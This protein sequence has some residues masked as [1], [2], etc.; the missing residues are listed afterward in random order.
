[1]EC[2]QDSS[3][4]YKLELQPTGHQYNKTNLTATIWTQKPIISVHTL[5]SENSL[6]GSAYINCSH[7]K[8]KTT[9]EG[10]QGGELNHIISIELTFQLVYPRH[11]AALNSRDCRLWH[12]MKHS[13]HLIIYH[14]FPLRKHHLSRT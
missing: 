1:M 7:F 11:Y 3:K 13:H 9:Q 6:L 14:A 2:T 4:P 5:W 8:V 12:P 10:P